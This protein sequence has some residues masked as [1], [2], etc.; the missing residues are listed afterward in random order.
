MLVTALEASQDV[1]KWVLVTERL[2]HEETKI[3]DRELNDTELKLMGSKH[4]VNKR[5]PKCYHCGKNGHIKRDCHLL[6]TNGNFKSNPRKKE[7]FC[8]LRK[9]RANQVTLVI[10]LL[11]SS[12]IMRYYPRIKGATGSWTPEQH[13]TCVMMLRNSLISENW[14]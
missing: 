10:A 6:N 8:S 7:T 1:P 12:H 4:H 2:L 13:V 14:M 3:K 5:G 9:H 11:D